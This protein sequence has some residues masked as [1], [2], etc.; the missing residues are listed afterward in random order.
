MNTIKSKSIDMTG[1]CRNLI[2]KVTWT[3][4]GSI[5]GSELAKSEI[6]TR[7]TLLNFVGFFCY[8]LLK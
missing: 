7:G 2:E 3:G 4:L 5:F 8:Y 6:K 1:T